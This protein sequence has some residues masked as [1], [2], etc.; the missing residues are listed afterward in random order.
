MSDKSTPPPLP[1]RSS[2]FF[3]FFYNN[4]NNDNNTTEVDQPPSIPSRSTK[5]VLSS[6]DSIER[7]KGEAQPPLASNDNIG[8]SSELPLTSPLQDVNPTTSVQATTTRFGLFANMKKKLQD[9]V[10]AVSESV[11]LSASLSIAFNTGIFPHHRAPS[12]QH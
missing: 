4:N 7:N 2:S 10:K 12:K 3:S 6:L 5:P 8:M 9:G 1:P 11:P